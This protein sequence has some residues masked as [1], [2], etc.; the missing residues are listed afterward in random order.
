MSSARSGAASEFLARRMRDSV[1]VVVVVADNSAGVLHAIRDGTDDEPACTTPRLYR[2][3]VSRHTRSIECYPP[4]Y[5]RWCRRCVEE[6]LDV[7]P[8]DD[9]RCGG[10]R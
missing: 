5:K 6:V 9:V 4:G 8:D 1:D 10:D 2:T 7:V 3:G